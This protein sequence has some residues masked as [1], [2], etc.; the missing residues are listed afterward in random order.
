MERVPSRPRPNAFERHAEVGF[1]HH[2]DY[3]VEDAYYSIPERD[4]RTLA[5]S[6]LT[7]LAVLELSLI[8]I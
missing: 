5:D 1:H 3:W 4:A 2:A 7:A 8:H 6:A